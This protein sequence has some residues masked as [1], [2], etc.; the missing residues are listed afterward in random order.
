MTKYAPKEWEVA[1]PYTMGV[2][3]RD[4]L[5]TSFPKAGRTWIALFFEYYNRYSGEG[6]PIY[7]THHTSNIS[8]KKNVLLI[9]NPCDVLVSLYFHK[10]FRRDMELPGFDEFIR[11]WLPVFNKS[12][13]EWSEYTDNKIVVRYED[14]FER[15]TWKKILKHFDMGMN[16]RI[17]DVAIDRTEFNNLKNNLG[18]VMEFRNYWKYLAREK[19]LRVL[20]PKENDSHKFRRGKAGGYVDYLSTKEIEFVRDNFS[21]G[22]GLEQH[23]NYYKEVFDKYLEG[24]K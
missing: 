16:K 1:Y 6:K 3:H 22:K 15:D 21:F 20:N 9:R 11:A 12:H 8:Y 7:T 2:F 10:K 17:F 4:N 13:R 18:R 24:K 14:L 5:V 19:G 23:T